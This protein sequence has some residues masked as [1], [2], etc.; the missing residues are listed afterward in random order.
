M[1][2]LKSYQSFYY[3][4]EGIVKKKYTT[5]KITLISFT[6]NNLE[7]QVNLLNLIKL[8]IWSLRLN[9]E[10]Y[11]G[12]DMCPR[13][14]WWGQLPS[15]PHPPA[16]G[17]GPPSNPLGNPRPL[18]P[19]PPPLPLGFWPFLPPGPA[20]RKSPLWAT[21]GPNGAA[22]GGNGGIAKLKI[23]IFSLV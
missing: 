8:N 17:Q 7:K 23:T 14:W 18:P 9:N 2:T 5:M 3:Q 6:H 21:M 4:F 10:A 22:N 15:P 12:V 16:H 1:H 19:E 20:F 13:G 11:H